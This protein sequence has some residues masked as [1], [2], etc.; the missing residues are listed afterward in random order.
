VR[1]PFAL[2]LFLMLMPALPAQGQY[3]DPAPNRQAT[4]TK[5]SQMI[6]HSALEA[7]PFETFGTLIRTAGV[8]GGIVNLY[9]DCSAES[10]RVISIA[11]ESPLDQA[12]DTLATS[13]DSQW[14]VQNGVINMLPQGN[15]RLLLIHITRFEWDKVAPL[16]GVLRRV[17][18]LPEVLQGAQD[19]GL[20]PQPFEHASGVICIRNCPVEKPKPEIIVERDVDLLTLLNHVVAEHPGASWAYWEHHRCSNGTL[21]AFSAAE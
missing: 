18:N 3:Q 8:S 1:R 10:K 14:H 11:E 6:L 4:R 12:F 7:T 9:Q 19:L 20:S 2:V 16:D 17:S 21:F 15:V 5:L 13:I